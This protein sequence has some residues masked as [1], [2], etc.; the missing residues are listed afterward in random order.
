MALT[1]KTAIVTAAA[2]GSARASCGASWPRGARVA[3]ADVNEAA[4]KALADE[5]GAA[6]IALKADV[7]Q[8]A[9][10]AAMVRDAHAAFGRLDIVVNNAG[11]GH[12]PR[13]LETLSEEEF[14]RLWAVNAKSVYLTAR[15]AVP[16]MKAAGGGVILNIASTGASARGRT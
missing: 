16:L 15:H 3:I 2:R 10:V 5:L 6:T 11:I 4:A 1:G 7:S 13:A 8:D 12:T 14:D 9:D